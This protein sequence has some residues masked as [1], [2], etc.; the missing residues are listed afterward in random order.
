[1][2]QV[3]APEPPSRGD[4]GVVSSPLWG[5]DQ[6]H[7]VPPPTSRGLVGSR[8]PP[9]L[10]RGSCQRPERQQDPEGGESGW[11]A[12]GTGRR[13]NGEHPG[14][15]GTT[16]RD[17]AVL[18]PLSTL[19]VSR[20]PGSGA[21]T[22]PHLTLPEPAPPPQPESPPPLP[23]PSSLLSWLSR[24]RE[25]RPT[26]R[27]AKQRTS[28]PGASTAFRARLQEDWL[29]R[30]A[31][32]RWWAEPGSAPE[33]GAVAYEAG[34]PRRSRGVLP[35]SPEP[36]EEAPRQPRRPASR[37]HPGCSSQFCGLGSR[38]CRDSL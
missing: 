28:L 35:R 38:L 8:A 10:P 32:L 33:A 5:H 6:S 23:E 14:G 21:Q 24:R 18:R 25:L 9:Y 22:A 34:V 37:L 15:L 30:T 16:T 7:Q 2:R 20:V 13:V 11:A 4:E 36:G 31:Y 12:P 26:P 27:P 29:E 3:P 17:P 1:M 19:A